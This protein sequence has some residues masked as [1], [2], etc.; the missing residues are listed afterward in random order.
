[1]EYKLQNSNELSSTSGSSPGIL[2][3]M[4]EHQTQ[5][6]GWMLTYEYIIPY[7]VLYY[8]PQTN[9]LQMHSHVY[10]PSSY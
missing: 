6:N 9:N 8:T 2:D 5:T 3:G 4:P 10:P 7:L 1:M